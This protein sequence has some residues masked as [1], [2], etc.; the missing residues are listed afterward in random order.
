MRSEIGLLLRP[1]PRRASERARWLDSAIRAYGHYW[2]PVFR[3]K[4]PE[5]T[6]RRFAPIRRAHA[7]Q[8]PFPARSGESRG[9]TTSSQW[10]LTEET[11]C[12]PSTPL[13][14]PPP[15]DDAN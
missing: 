4:R 9:T 10:V 7:S 8:M 1:G 13:S 14:A 5:P 15:A 12:S 6:Y 2:G 3:A 11:L